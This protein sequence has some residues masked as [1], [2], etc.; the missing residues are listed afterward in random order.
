MSGRPEP[1]RNANGLAALV[2]AFANALMMLGVGMSWW[3]LDDTQQILWAVFI[4]A[5]VALASYYVAWK[6]ARRRVTPT[7]DPRDDDG[8]P[9][10]SAGK[11]RAA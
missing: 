7:S 10:V 8:N 1:V 3:A 11:A 4:Q 9:L 5:T 2:I 6:W